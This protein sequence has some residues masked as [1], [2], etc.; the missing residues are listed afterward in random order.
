MN[1]AEGSEVAEAAA[2]LQ[3][4]VTKRAVASCR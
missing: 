4:V 2:R 3:P 1:V